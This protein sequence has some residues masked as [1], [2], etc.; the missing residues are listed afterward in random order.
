M[1]IGISVSS[2]YPDIA[3]KVAADWMVERTRAANTAGLDYF[4]CRRSPF[5]Q[6]ALLSK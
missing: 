4:V 1:K 6:N 2:S 5:N 3:P